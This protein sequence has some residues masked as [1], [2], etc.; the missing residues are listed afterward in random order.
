MAWLDCVATGKNFC[1]G[2]YMRGNHSNIACKAKERVGALE[3][4]FPFM[5]P[6]SVLNPLTVNLF[7]NLYYHTSVQKASIEHC[8]HRSIFLSS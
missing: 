4:S 7:N 3:L 8:T 2:I 6:V 5:M 1:R